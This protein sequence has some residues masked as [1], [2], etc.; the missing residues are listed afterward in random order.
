M[1]GQLVT[2]STKC[3]SHNSAFPPKFRTSQVQSWT[4]YIQLYS[5][6]ITL[7][8]S[9]TPVKSRDSMLWIPLSCVIFHYCLDCWYLFWFVM[10][11]HMYELYL[12]FGPNTCK[13]E[14]VGVFSSVLLHLGVTDYNRTWEVLSP[15]LA[16]SDVLCTWSQ[17]KV[18][19]DERGV[20]LGYDDNEK[21]PIGCSVIN[22]YPVDKGMIHQ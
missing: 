18:Q 20:C 2:W 15:Q 5:L 19:T 13:Q 16:A 17:N 10:Y 6:R 11:F 21:A 7:L 22:D 9:V 8:F 4:G 3:C 14:A 1:Q 12:T